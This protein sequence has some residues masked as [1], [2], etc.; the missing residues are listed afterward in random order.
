MKRKYVWPIL[1]L[2]ITLVLSCTCTAPVNFIGIREP[3]NTPTKTKTTTQTPIQVDMVTPTLA[4]T[5]VNSYSGPYKLISVIDYY[6]DTYASPVNDE[7]KRA[8]NQPNS[9]LVTWEITNESI[10]ITW[11]DHLC[12]DSDTATNDIRYN[13][14][15]PEALNPGES[16][17]VGAKGAKW[18]KDTGCYGSSP[19]SNSN[20]TE[21][22]YKMWAGPTSTPDP[23]NMTEG[24]R[25]SLIVNTIYYRM[26]VNSLGG[27]IL[28]VHFPFLFRTTTN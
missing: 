4:E 7:Y 22:G 23:F 1:I 27:S 25:T 19:V 15:I 17:Q 2:I 6:D 28:K 24:F 8:K 9:E 18:Y 20:W 11:Q 16:V 10:S 26:L 21:F 14:K 5:K 3:S 12:G 13:W